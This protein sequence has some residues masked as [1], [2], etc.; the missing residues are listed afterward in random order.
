M[1]EIKEVL[2]KKDIKL[3]AK[4]PLKLYK[5]CPYYVPSLLGDEINMFNPK[6]NFNLKDN[7]MKAF[8]CY[9]DGE[10]VGRIAGMINNVENAKGEEK[11]VRFSRFE[12]IDDIEV[13]KALFGA[14]EKFGKENGVDTIHGPWGFTDQDREG[15]LTFGFNER[16]TY[17]TCYSYPYFC[18]NMVKLGFEDESKWV[19]KRFVIKNYDRIETI[20]EKLKAKYKLKEIAEDM[21]VKQILANYGDKFFD[22]LNEAYG[23]LD[24]YIP[25]EGKSRDALL[26]QFATI[27]NT[28]YISFLI[29]E[30]DDIAAFGVVLPSIAEALVKNRGK[31]FPTGFISVLKSIKKPKELEMALIG[32]AK[33]Y[34]NTGVNAITISRIM[35]NV[36]EDG[37]ENIESNPMLETNLNILA[38]WKFTD[39]EIVKKRQ[40]YKK[41]IG[42]L[43]AE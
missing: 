39:S 3:F 2:T 33:K 9:K 16:S 19:E 12:C 30:D 43:I 29:D 10:L 13:F 42:S 18:E 40:T 36:V 32:V 6:V 27:V 20:A 28:R 17:A 14:V 22:V 38:Q 21:S 4:Y 1:I 34:V 5:D 8:L 23:H 26:S 37:I 35:H 11:F 25:L 41:K 31:L 15:M 7:L 24:G